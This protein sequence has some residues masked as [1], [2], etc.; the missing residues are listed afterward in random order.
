[1][2]QNVLSATK[3]KIVKI[4]ILEKS[5]PSLINLECLSISKDEQCIEKPNHTMITVE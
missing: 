5:Y 2:N 1:L 3:Y 4:K